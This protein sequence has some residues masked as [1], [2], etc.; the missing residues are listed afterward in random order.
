MTETA[1]P[2]HPHP[3]VREIHN[4]LEGVFHPLVELAG[5]TI[6]NA[7]DQ[8]TEA[9][10]NVLE[11]VGYLF[12]LAARDARPPWAGAENV[13]PPPTPSGADF[14]ELWARWMEFGKTVSG[15]IDVFQ[16]PNRFMWAAGSVETQLDVDQLAAVAQIIDDAQVLSRLAH[17]DD[18][19]EVRKEIERLLDTL[20]PPPTG[21]TA[22][23]TATRRDR[24]LAEVHWKIQAVIERYRDAG[25]PIPDAWPGSGF[26]EARDG[27]NAAPY[28]PRP[29]EASWRLLAWRGGN[30]LRGGNRRAMNWR[31]L[32]DRVREATKEDSPE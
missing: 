10:G 17:P 26:R 11:L 9:H 24:H 25:N 32:R 14:E 30:E 21:P 16:Q 31:Y 6:G 19:W 29:S 28:E 3:G 8:I 1:H 18:R 7:I 23:A 22:R 15:L 27:D 12:Q 5:T 4:L 2:E 13:T 20:A